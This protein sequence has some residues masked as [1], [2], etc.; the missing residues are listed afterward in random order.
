MNRAPI[1][2]TISFLVV[3]AVLAIT[4]EVPHYSSMVGFST[5]LWCSLVVTVCLVAV[6]AWLWFGKFRGEDLYVAAGSTLLFTF[7]VVFGLLSWSNRFLSHQRCDTASYQL[8]SY[9]ARHSSG[10]GITESQALQPN[11][12]LVTIIYEGEAKTFTIRQPIEEGG[13]TNPIKLEFCKGLL[14][15]AYLQ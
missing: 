2:I 12:W 7:V 1:Y 3:L 10:Y 9:E 13:V 14:G 6:F 11:H 8:L 5:L 15:T 4:F